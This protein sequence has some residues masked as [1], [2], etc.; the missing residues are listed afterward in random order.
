[1]KKTTNYNLNQI[2]LID[3]PPDITKHSEN[4]ETIDTELKNLSDAIGDVDFSEELEKKVDKV[5]GMGLSE[6]NFTDDEKTKLSNIEKN[7]QKN[8][9]TSVNSEIGAVSLTASDVGAIPSTEK[10]AS[11]GVATL[12]STG[13]V[14]PGQLTSRILLIMGTSETLNLNCEGA[15]L[16]TNTST[17]TI[18]TI[19]TNASVPFPTGTEI[20]I[21]QGA[22]GKVEIVGSSG[23]TIRSSGN[24][25]F[26][27]NQYETVAL[28][29][30]ETNE[31][32]LVGAL[33]A[34]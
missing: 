26:I 28:K 13:K 11:S 5:D 29:K 22:A 23:V 15:F 10:G 20:E 31:W 8:T 27:A 14:T 4:F 16:K 6:A 32:W 25:R 12:T 30:V 33:S 21:G 19:P 18:I 3:S 17:K 1:M 2:E 34:D 9:V 24:K 7:A